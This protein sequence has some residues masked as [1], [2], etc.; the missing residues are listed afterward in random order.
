MKE[1]S[2]V[3]LLIDMPADFSTYVLYGICW[4]KNLIQR[5]TW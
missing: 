3:D 5:L 1:T 4:S 2:D